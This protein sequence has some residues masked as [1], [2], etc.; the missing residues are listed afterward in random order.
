VVISPVN[1][2]PVI[3]GAPS[4]LTVIAGEPYTLDFS[5]FITD[6]D[7]ATSD[8]WLMTDTSHAT[9][10]G[11]LITFTYPPTVG[12]E[13]VTITVTDGLDSSTWPVYVTVIIPWEIKIYEVDYVYVKAYLASYLELE[14][15]L[16]VTL[17]GVPPAN[18]TSVGIIFVLRT[19]PPCGRGISSPRK[20]SGRRRRPELVGE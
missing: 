14:I 9:V 2:A 12:S 1:D 10:D 16:N 4:E 17:P 3:S 13:L 19:A 15:D 7:N 8:L 5:P 18:L 6:V 11:L 20:R